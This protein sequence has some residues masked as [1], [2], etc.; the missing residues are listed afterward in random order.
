MLGGLTPM[1]AAPVEFGQPQTFSTNATNSVINPVSPVL[2][3][4]DA[5]QGTDYMTMVK[6]YAPYVIGAVVLY[7]LILK[8]K[9]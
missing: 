3:T 2:P 6:K 5:P 7:Y 4:S 9:K 1:G 8:N